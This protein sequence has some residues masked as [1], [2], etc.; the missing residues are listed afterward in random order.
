[1]HLPSYPARNHSLVSAAQTDNVSGRAASN[2]A[3][4]MVATF[5]KPLRVKAF[6]LRSLSVLINNPF[7]L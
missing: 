4:R 5:T 3:P 1:M 6:R 7:A 2:N